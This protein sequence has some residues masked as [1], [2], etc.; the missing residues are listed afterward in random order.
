MKFNIYTLG[1]KVN[2]YESNVMRESLLKEGFVEVTKN[3][4]ADISIINTCTVTNTADSKSRKMVHHAKSENPDAIIVVC[5]C[6]TQSKKDEVFVDGADIIIGNQNK[7]NIV[8]YIYDYLK[9]HEKS[10]DVKKLIN[11]PFETMILNNFDKTRAFVKIQDGCNNFCSYC[12]IPFTRGNVRSKKKED[13]LAEVNNLVNQ[14]HREIV[15]TGIHT[16]HY[17]SEFKNYSFYNLLTDL[18]KVDGLERIRISSIEITEINADII[19]LLKENSVLVNHMHIPIQSG[20]DSVLKRMNRKYDKE[21]FLEKIN[22]IRSVRPDISITTDVI[23]GFPGESEEEFLETIDTINKIH[24]SKLHVFAYSK[25]DGTKAATLENQ[26]PDQIK[27]QRVKKLLELSK[28]LEEEYMRSFLNKKLVFIP[29]TY[30][31]GFWVGHTENYLLVKKKSSDL[32]KK[33]ID[34]GIFQKIEYPYCRCE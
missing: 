27:K 14:G 1:C 20:S 15:L 11:V 8:D 9:N 31:D 3:E 10:I 17:G 30:K 28:K 26:I 33:D 24:F 18:V 29:E 2:A 22:K 23:V 16:G 21:Y 25:R 13:V 6:L 4:K 7:S 34:E 32:K 19:E 5:G 12:I